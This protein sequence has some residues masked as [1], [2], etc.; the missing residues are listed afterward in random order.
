MNVRAQQLDH[1]WHGR[2]V[3]NQ[4]E[5]RLFLDQAATQI[6][7]ILFWFAG[8]LGFVQKR[9]GKAV[10]VFRE[11]SDPVSV[12]RVA[13]HEEAVVGEGLSLFASEFDKLHAR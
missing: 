4:G 2:R 1:E 8:D 3:C 13:D 12:V 10:A 9:S 11:L 6:E 7:V 5:Q